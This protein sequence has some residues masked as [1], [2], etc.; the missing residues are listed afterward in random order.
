M[1]GK[2]ALHAYPYQV[3]LQRVFLKEVQS[4]NSTDEVEFLH[5]CGAAIIGKEFILTGAHC[6]EGLTPG[7]FSIL[8][9]TNKLN[10][11]SL[12]PDENG[13]RFFIKSIKIHP[14]YKALVT[15]DI[16][17]LRL[18]EAIEFGP[19]MQPIKFSRTFIGAGINCIL[20]GWGFTD[21]HQTQPLPNILQHISL[22][23]IPNDRCAYR[24]TPNEICTFSRKNEGSCTV[25]EL[26]K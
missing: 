26:N 12:N 2:D 3:S 24:V 16:A 11:E 7:N 25:S 15:S 20:T 23:S 21:P 6:V 8:A 18:T 1:G 10:D 14:N 22:P 19:T 5:M 4:T 13:K 17:I 9:G